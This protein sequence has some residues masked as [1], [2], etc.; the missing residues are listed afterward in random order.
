MML[1]VLVSLLVLLI[2]YW[3]ANQGLFDAFIHLTCVVIAGVLAF[4]LWEPVTVGFLLT[5]GGFDG[6]AWG[7][8]LGFLFLGFLFLLRFLIDLSTPKRPTLPPL[9]NLTAGALLG[10]LSGILTM[11]I[12]LI[13]VG[14][15]STSRELLGYTGWTRS[16]ESSGKPMQTAPG[17]PCSLLTEF[18]QG[19]FN[20]LSDGSCSPFMSNATLA[21]YRP[22]IAQDGGSLFRDSLRE[23]RGN[24]TLAPG[25]FT[26]DGFYYD[27]KYPI[28]SGSMG[29]YAV[30]FSFKPTSFDAAGSFSLS[31]SQ[32]RLIAPDNGGAI[33]EFP[34]E[35]SQ[36]KNTESG[37][38]M[39]RY[40]FKS[41]TAFATL[42]T[43][44]EGKICLVFASLPFQKS[45]PKM[46]IL[47]GLRITL[48]EL[49]ANPLALGVAVENAG[50]KIAIPAD[51]SAPVI[52]AQ[53]L[54]LDRSLSGI[55]L[56]KNGLP[57]TLQEESGS[58]FTGAAKHIKKN[59]IAKSDV[60][61][62]AQSSSEKIA[63]L[64]IS[65]DS[66]ADLYNMDKTRKIAE[67]VGKSGIPMLVDTNGNLYEPFGYIWVNTN[68]DEWEI[69][70]ESPSDGFTVKQFQRGENAGFI[71]VLYRL[72]IGIK[73]T[74]VILRDP[75]ASLSKAKV[76][77]TAELNVEGKAVVN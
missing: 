76:L 5:G 52:P 40:E 4:S 24:S 9:V 26:I 72:P 8:C 2:A 71:D 69:F 35:F 34:I 14:H 19:F 74:M 28:R 66:T 48:P 67:K 32:V 55:M 49:N 43:P 33:S 23:G 57:G 37:R 41:E 11:G 56:N 58:I 6:Y 46:I 13:A 30:L 63:K 18:T 54:V 73:I 31:S 15:L 50:E 45:P 17:S 20:L 77:G 22:G 39:I 64:K 61:E 38:S 16:A 29:A 59:P 36:E 10:L 25:T 75:S 62:I 70:L 27:P 42:E 47:K 21:S 12:M 51:E 60:R 7:L 53:E 68:T 44:T 65:R 1:S 3:W